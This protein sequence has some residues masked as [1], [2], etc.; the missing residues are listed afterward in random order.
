ME[1]VYTQKITLCM[2][3]SAYTHAHLDILHKF[4]TVSI[5]RLQFQIKE[6]NTPNK[7]AQ[8]FNVWLIQIHQN[9]FFRRVPKL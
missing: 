1:C 3:F 8:H 7:I 9:T 2:H 6:R 5:F 4:N